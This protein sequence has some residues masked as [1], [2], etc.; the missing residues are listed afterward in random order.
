MQPDTRHSQ[1]AV[2]DVPSMSSPGVSVVNG[3]A[4]EAPKARE[5]Q[6]GWAGTPLPQRL[7]VIKRARREIAARARELAAAIEATQRPIAD[8]LVAEV[9]PLADACRFLEREASQLLAPVRLHARSRPLWL[10]GVDIEVRREP[11][12]TILII[13]PSNYPLFLPGV[14]V[15]QALAAGN[16]VLLKPGHGGSAAALALAH[17]L[18]IA[19]LPTDLLRV[20]PEAPEAARAAIMT[21]VDKV[22]LTGSADTGRAVLA[23]LAP[24]LTPATMELSGCDA[25]F[26]RADADL[27]LVARALAFSLRLNGGATCIAPRRLF[28]ARALANSLEARLGEL[29]QTI[30]ACQV[31]ARVSQPVV[32]AL[33]QGARLIAGRLLP[34]MALAPLVVADASPSMR[35]LQEDV[36]GPV[37]AVV[38]VRDDEDALHAAAQ[39]P[40]ALGATIFGKEDGAQPLATRLRA[41]VV[42]I[43]DLIVPT[44][45]PRLPFGGRGRSGYGVT[46]GAEGLL[47]LTAVKAIAVRHGRWH[48]HFDAG[49]ARDTEFFQ[50]YIT[51]AHGATLRERASACWA[52][53]QGIVTRGMGRQHRQ[54]GR[55]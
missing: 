15:L 11:L 43:N 39:C 54:E 5:A 26:V 36:L 25:A 14:Q 20:L 23:E 55:P 49:N 2:R 51:A 30:P 17:V 6:P 12:G 8:T 34:G 21:G 27:D 16:G 31:E 10:R 41:G 40:Y 53:L 46:R 4:R 44:A 37:L 3:T 7:Q 28:V 18:G 42:V 13:G 33:E 1:S 50:A 9:L 48:P 38:S 24:H 47:E 22:L 19:G 52:L 32:D 35:L 45:D 29:V